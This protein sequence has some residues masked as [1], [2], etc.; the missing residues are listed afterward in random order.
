MQRAIS[1]GTAGNGISTIALYRIS[2]DDRLP[3]PHYDVAW[4][5]NAAGT[6]PRKITLHAGTVQPSM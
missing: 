4:I 5:V 3:V 6:A 2:D 1:S